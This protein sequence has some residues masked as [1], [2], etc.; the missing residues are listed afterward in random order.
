MSFVNEKASFEKFGS[1]FQENLVQIILDDRVFCDQISEVLDS[2]FLELKYLR[3][4][5]DKVLDYRK[6]YGTHPSR[7][8][9]TTILRTEIDKEPELL[10]KQTR[11]FYARL[12]TNE[13]SLDG[14]QHIKDVSLDF[15]KKQKL[16]EAMIKSVG[17]I[18]NSS[19]DEIS[20]IINDALKLGTDNN[21]GYDFIVDFEKRFE[22][23]ARNPLSTGWDLIDNIMKGGLG[24]GELGV[25]I[26]PTGAGK[27]MA[28]VHLG[29]EALKAGKNVVHYSLELQDKV[30]A[31][32]YDSCI[33][34]ILLS[35]VKDQKD[36]VW[37]SVKDVKGKLIVKEYPTKSATTLTIKNHLEKLKRKDFKVDMVIIDYGDLIRPIN[38]QREKRNELE[39]IY[40]EM[41]ALAQIYGCPVW[42]ASQTNRSGL[43]AEV[44]TME[45]ISEAFN[46]CFVADFIFTISRTIKDKNTNEGRIFVAKNRNGPDGLVFPIFMDTANVKIKVLQ[47]S[48]ES[49]TEIIENATKKQ[50]ENLKQKY[51]DYKKQK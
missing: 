27:S 16:K 40:E 8:T 12:Q 11:E 5:V 42:T 30:V 48:T 26:A 39:S 25:V 33:S 34:G 19:Y 7:D 50:E 46:K 36:M 24:K 10:Q 9:M 2:N 15:C 1:K 3:L 35:D 21:H 32:R 20:K 51:R 14:E 28:L 29:A 23:L 17:L 45:S 49:A 44:I 13:F 38:A 43:N 6:K 4:F 22:V 37:E 31:L 47:Q 41:R 18:Q